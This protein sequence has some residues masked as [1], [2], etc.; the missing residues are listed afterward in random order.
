RARAELDA[1]NRRDQAELRREHAGRRA[2]AKLL[3]IGE[4]RARAFPTDWTSYAPP[5]PAFLGVRAI[6]EIPLSDLAEIVDWSPLFHAW[7]IRG[8]YPKLLEDPKVGERARELYG[9]ARQLLDRIAREKRLT[10]RGV[11]GFFPAAA[12]GDDLEVF[13]DD[14]RQSPLAMIHTL[15]E[16]AAKPEGQFC[17]ALADYVAPRASGVPDWIGFFAVT[18][19][20]G[21]EELTALFR[22]EHDDYRAIMAQALGDRLA[23]AFAEW[24]HR[25]ARR[26]WGF[27]AAE[28]LS[29]DDLIHEKYRGIRPAPGYPACP[30]HTEKPKIFRLLGVTEHAGIRLTESM[31]MWPASSVCGMIFS[32][33]KAKYF[34]VGRIGRD[35]MLDYHRRKGVDL[36]VAERWL[37]ANLNYDPDEG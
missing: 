15:R 25:Q 20:H 1:A 19:G 21:M 6:P 14:A 16:Q 4:A 31:A 26:D 13:A 2:I 32:H 37:R 5:R 24:I 28:N 11:Y 29:T 27:G 12:A 23:E 36:K 22:G 3:P 18:A 10:A 33:P 35:Q 30:D 8:R 9:D 34:S 7:E 17:R